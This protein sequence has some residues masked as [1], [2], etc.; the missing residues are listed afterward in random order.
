[1]VKET[2]YYDMLGV[3]PTAS[4]DELKKAY[5]KLALK[6]HPD[7][8]PNEGEKVLYSLVFLVFQYRNAYFMKKF[9][10]IIKTYHHHCHFFESMLGFPW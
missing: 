3:K 4:Q 8:N 10:L 6:Y 9:T 1:M 5:R 7:K 2:G